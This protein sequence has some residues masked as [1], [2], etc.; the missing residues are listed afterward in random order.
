MRLTTENIQ[1]LAENLT[2]EQMASLLSEGAPAP[3]PQPTQGQQQQPQQPMHTANPQA[4]ENKDKQPQG[5][6]PSNSQQNINMLATAIK[7]PKSKL[8]TTMKPDEV[9]SLMQS[10]NIPDNDVLQTISFALNSKN[11]VQSGKRGI[12]VLVLY[13]RSKQY[14]FAQDILSKLKENG[15]DVNNLAESVRN[16]YQK[17]V[18]DNGRNALNESVTVNGKTF[19]RPSKIQESISKYYDLNTKL[20][21][22]QKR[23]DLLESKGYSFG[24]VR[25]FMTITQSR[26]KALNESLSAVK[27]SIAFYNRHK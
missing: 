16:G 5:N 25:N 13:L 8:N 24:I 27:Y 23:M 14:A 7:N 12:Q 18:F 1:W 17:T 19:R 22:V 26:R 2:N 20:N 21:E 6:Q 4:P 10:K 11:A 9:T 15:I 3:A